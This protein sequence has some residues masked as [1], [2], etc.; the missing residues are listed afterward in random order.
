[1]LV[2]VNND[3]G[4]MVEKTKNNNKQQIKQTSNEEISRDSEWPV[5]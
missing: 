5:K 3:A 2:H 4:G 1:M